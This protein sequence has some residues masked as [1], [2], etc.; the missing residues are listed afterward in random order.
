MEAEIVSSVPG[1]A[2]GS[3]AIAS[4]YGDLVFVAG[5]IPLDPEGRLLERYDDLPADVRARF[6]TGRAP[7]DLRDERIIVQTWAVYENMSRVLEHLGMSLAHVMLQRLY[8]TD[9]NQF[10]AVERVR[11]D[12]FGEGKVPPT[13]TAGVTSL[14]IPQVLIEIECIAHRR[15]GSSER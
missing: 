13:T 11:T 3:Y 1:I 7:T 10:N 14:V 9:V 12:V 4:S 6:V 8:L 2:G 15:L 5:Q